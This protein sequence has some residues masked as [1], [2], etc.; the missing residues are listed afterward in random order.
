M[1]DP[2]FNC[3]NS[4]VEKISPI[5]SKSSPLR[6][7]QIS[8][9]TVNPSSTTEMESNDRLLGALDKIF[10]YLLNR[11]RL[12][13][14]E[15]S[16]SKL[17]IQ[18]NRQE[19]L[20]K[21]KQEFQSELKLFRQEFFFLMKNLSTFEQVL[22]FISQGI[23]NRT[24]NGIRRLTQAEVRLA[25]LEA[26]VDDKSGDVKVEPSGNEEDVCLVERTILTI[27]LTREESV[28]QDICDSSTDPPVQQPKGEVKVFT[29]IEP[30]EANQ[31]CSTSKEPAE[32]MHD[33]NANEIPL[34]VP[35]IAE[36]M[37]ISR[38]LF[39]TI[40]EKRFL[41]PQEE[42]PCLM[43]SLAS[44]VT[45]KRCL[46]ANYCSKKCQ[47]SHWEQYHHVTCVPR[48]ALISE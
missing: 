45:C 46:K 20:L 6:S 28:K 37:T 33:L 9:G 30:N 19:E 26:G 24:P 35:S 5:S 48:Q 8:E 10:L 22:C 15:K 34:T 39:E 29:K 18:G 17:A 27:D 3:I 13:E 12:K 23:E 11:R 4:E 16:A 38:Q 41:L 43:C 31:D 44:R 14:R 32:F 2:L 42:Y 25:M 1:D 7:Q 40:G 36:V 21:V 47:E